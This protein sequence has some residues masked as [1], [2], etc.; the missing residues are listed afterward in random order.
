MLRPLYLYSIDAQDT[1]KHPDFAG[2][3]H[4]FFCCYDILLRNSSYLRVF[5]STFKISRAEGERMA[6]VFF[7]SYNYSLIE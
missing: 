3:F 7:F 5:N 6:G 1:E 4:F 2:F